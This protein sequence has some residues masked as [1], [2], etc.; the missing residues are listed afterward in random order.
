MRRGIVVTDIVA[1]TTALLAAHV[2]RFGVVP[3][4]GPLASVV[5]LGPLTAAA[6]LALGLY[7]DRPDAEVGRVVLGVTAALASHVF[8]AFW[9]EVYLSR[10]WLALSWVLACTRDRDSRR[11][12]AGFQ[13]LLLT[14]VSRPTCQSMRRS[15]SRS[16]PISIPPVRTNQSRAAPF[17][18]GFVFLT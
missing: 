5:L 18:R 3:E 16:I 13:S 2:L 8:I 15:A 4:D 9:T 17:Q 11:L 12:A 7:R 1:V 6:F 14:A 10:T